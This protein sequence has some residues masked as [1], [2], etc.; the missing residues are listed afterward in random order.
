MA[1]DQALLERAGRQCERWLR[2][3][4]WQPHCLSFGR[5]EPAIRRYDPIQI[6]ARGLD[7]VRRPT[8]GRAVWHGP[9]VTYSIAAPT[10]ALGALR[11]AYLEIHRML[12]RAL[13]A[14][15]APAEIA[16]SHPPPRLDAGACFAQ[17][18]GGE[19]LVGGRKV[20][21]SAQLREGEAL[22]QHG[23]ILLHDE[24]TVVHSV[25]RDAATRPAPIPTAWIAPETKAEE[26]AEAVAQ[27]AAARWGGIWNREPPVDSVLELAAAHVPRF[28]SDAWTWRM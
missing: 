1:I 16:A 11:H 3:Y 2:L 25:S 4:R 13:R 10:R 9:E 18:V 26:I 15:G 7:V 5:H 17:P 20:V 28:R 19:I 8:G 22:L 6:A 21:G 27:A 12:L 14:L 23:S 24:Q